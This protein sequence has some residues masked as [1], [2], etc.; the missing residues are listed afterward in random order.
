M[1]RSLGCGADG[2]KTGKLTLSTQQRF[3]TWLSSSKVKGGER[4]GLG[5][6]FHMRCPIY[7]GALTFIA[8]TVVRLRAPI[9]FSHIVNREWCGGPLPASSVGVIQIPDLGVDTA[10]NDT[11]D[12]TWTINAVTDSVV[13]I[14][15]V[16][17]KIEDA[18]DKECINHYL[19]V[20]YVHREYLNFFFCAKS[21]HISPNEQQKQ[22]FYE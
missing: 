7:D 10:Y 5:P 15:F 6:A 18:D 11:V 2:R 3:G 22:Y 17:M 12:C 21:N 20:H 8:P 14:W 1:V 4:R 9:H 19:Q 16:G 13:L